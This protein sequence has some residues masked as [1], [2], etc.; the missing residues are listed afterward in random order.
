MDKNIQKLIWRF[1]ESWD[2]EGID[3]TLEKFSTED[4]ARIAS[5]DVELAQAI[6]KVKASLKKLEELADNY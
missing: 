2:K 6:I 4:L 5:E 3:D 1:L